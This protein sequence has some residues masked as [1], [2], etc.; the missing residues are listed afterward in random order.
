MDLFTI[1][2]IL[3]YLFSTAGYLVYLFV[4]KDYLQKAGVILLSAGFVCHT[5]VL[6]YKSLQAGYLPVHNMPETLLV[7]GWALAA[8]FLYFRWHYHLKILGVYAAPL[9]LIMILAAS[10]LP[11][12]AA[13]TRHIFKSFWFV[14]HIVT[15][16]MGEA[17]LA[18][19]C[20][21]GALYLLQEHAI[22]SKKR[23]FFFKRLPSLYLID[24]TG[25]A[26]IL[27]GFTLLTIGLVTGLIYARIVWG[28]LWSWDPKEIWS[29]MTWLVYAVLLHGRLTSGWHGRR[30]AIMSIIGFAFIIF[31]FFGVNFILEG[32]H[33]DFT[34]W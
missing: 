13:E 10:N 11:Q 20:G 3:C 27:S 21:A 28:Y 14:I 17:A 26:C 18:L 5:F 15:V 29:A 33:G 30:A 23:G 2:I 7:A 32:H 8:V 4:Q 24:T 25:S 6:I 19:A 34:R 31:T 1:P 22:K 16:F 12:E 9:L